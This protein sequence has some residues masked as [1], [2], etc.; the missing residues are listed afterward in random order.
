MTASII[1][2]IIKKD[3]FFL[4][5]LTRDG[6]VEKRELAGT[7]ESEAVTFPSDFS[8][9]HPG[10]TGVTVEH[11]SDPQKGIK[12]VRK[13]VREALDNNL[14]VCIQTIVL[15]MADTLNYIADTLQEDW[16]ANGQLIAQKGDKITPPML[17]EISR[18][19]TYLLEGD[20]GADVS[21]TE[22]IKL[23][24]KILIGYRLAVI[25]DSISGEYKDRVAEKL[26]TFFQLEPWHV[27]N[28]STHPLSV[29][30]TGW[31]NSVSF[32]CCD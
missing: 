31:L 12:D 10:R 17:L 14:D 32:T 6:K 8:R 30:V 27:T 24:W 4:V 1:R 7:C 23:L 29:K 3:V 20:T 21:N 13:A 25:R 18:Q 22:A 11:P 15:F 19:G 26:K 9:L 5:P 28:I 16:H 2:E